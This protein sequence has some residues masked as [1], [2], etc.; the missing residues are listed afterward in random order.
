MKTASVFY[1]RDF[2]PSPISFWVGPPSSFYVERTGQ[3]GRALSPSLCSNPI[4]E[5]RMQWAYLETNLNGV[6]LHFA[7]TL[8]LDHLLDVFNRK[9]LP[10]GANLIPGF[11]RPGLPNNHWLSRLPARSLSLKFRQDVIRFLTSNHRT[12]VE[13]QDFYENFDL[14]DAHEKMIADQGFVG[15]G[16]H[17]SP[18]RKAPVKARGRDLE[19]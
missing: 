2:R 5:S 15:A 18:Y 19:T 13:F 4:Y 9:V 1:S 8:E 10:K 3:D 14:Q 12:I 16:T 7:T 17:N 6:D 11:D